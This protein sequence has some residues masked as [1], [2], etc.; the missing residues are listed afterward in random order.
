MPR[1]WLEVS[2][3]QI[4]RNYRSIRQSTN[5]ALTLMP[6]VKADAY[7]HGAVAVSQVLEREG[8]QWLAVSN[9]EEGKALREAGIRARILVMADRVQTDPT[10]W[11]E[12]RLTPVIHDLDEIALLEAG[13]P[14]HLKV[15]TGMGRLGSNASAREI[16][17][18]VHGSRLEGLMTH[19]ASSADFTSEQTQSQI[20]R[21]SEI[22]SHLDISGIKP[23]WIHLASTNP[24]HFGVREAWGNMAR[25]GYA[26]Y[27]FVSQAKGT[28]PMKLLEDVQPAMSWKA[29]ILLCKEIQA[30][31]SVGYG[32][33]YRAQRLM[34]IGILGVGY[35]DGLPHRLSGRGQVLAGG[36]LV[37]MLGAVSMDLT[38]VD[39]TGT[40]LKAGDAVTLLGEENGHRIDARQMGRQAGTIA[41]A[42][43]CGIST[44]VP[45]IY[46]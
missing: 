3:D 22:R 1:T 40:T 29:S 4:A 46:I 8:V 13:E 31:E 14:Y 39:L 42:I 25:P 16:V 10:A 44:R 23:D 38:T 37:P 27:G 9:I 35:A 32:A 41:Y 33:M 34:R 17:H 6:V 45:R 21:F 19:F 43:L 20:T 5:E 15:D 12:H 11:K 18:A 28:A 24:L 30:G 7:R 36:N 2:L 26:L